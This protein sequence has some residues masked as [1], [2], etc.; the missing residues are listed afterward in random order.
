M[1]TTSL[2]LAG[3]DRAIASL[4]ASRS[5]DRIEA[6]LPYLQSPALTADQ[7]RALRALDI[8]LD[9][10]RAEIAEAIGLEAPKLVQL[11]RFSIGSVIR[12]ALPLLALFFLVSALAGFDWDEFVESLQDANWWLVAAWCGRVADAAH[13]PGGGHPR[14]GADPVAAR[15]GVR[16]AARDLLRQPGDPHCRGAD[17]RQR[18]VLPTSGR[19]RRSGH[20]HRCP[21]RGERVHRPG[22][23]ADHLADV[24][25]AVARSRPRGPDLRRRPARRHR[26]RTGR[27]RRHR[28]GVHPQAAFVRLRL[29]PPNR[30]RGV[31][32][33]ARPAFAT[34]PRHAVRR[35][36]HGRT[37]LRHGARHLHGWRSATPCRSRSCCS[38]TCACRCCPGSSPSPVASA[39]PRAV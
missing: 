2:I 29:G 35:Q 23:A 30:S 9:D 37:A 17:R 8:D 38:S 33:A 24:Q 31:R 7:R 25:L 27:A 4:V 21:R 15:A 36:P 28:R 1:F 20:G 11:R 22:D 14:G 26:P 34:S 13:R 5:N 6:C 18:P 3:R 32:R 39:S 10:L 16:A 12:I 19:T